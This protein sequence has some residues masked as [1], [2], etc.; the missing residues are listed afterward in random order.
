MP[1]LNLSNGITIKNK[2]EMS[3]YSELIIK[4]TGCTESDAAEIEEYM[5][6]IIFH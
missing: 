6:D 2:T 3:F 4:A 5:R 1:V